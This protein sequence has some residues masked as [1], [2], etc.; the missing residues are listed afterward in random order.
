MKMILAAAAALMLL[1]PGTIAF[2][3]SNNNGGNGGS[4]SGAA[5]DDANGRTK[6]CQKINDST[7]AEGQDVQCSSTAQQGTGANP[8]EGVTTPDATGSIGAAGDN[9]TDADNPNATA[10]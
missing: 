9:S 6:D 7:M 5:G 8:D 3:D 4:Q 10:Q 1:G 2:A